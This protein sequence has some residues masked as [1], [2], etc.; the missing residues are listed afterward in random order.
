MKRVSSPMRAASTSSSV[1]RCARMRSRTSSRSM[2]AHSARRRRRLGRRP[3]T[4]PAGADRKA[5]AASS[6]AAVRADHLLVDRPLRQPHRVRD[7]ARAE[8]PVR[9]DDRLAQAEQDRA[10]D[11]PRGR[12]RRAGRAACRGS[13]G[14]RALDTGPERIASRIAPHERFDG[15]SITFSATL[16]VKPSVTTTSTVA[17]REVE[18]LDVAGEVER[19]LGEPL[20]RR[21]HRRACPCPTPRRPTAA[22][23]AGA[24][25]RTHGLHEAGAHVG[26]LDEVLGARLDAGAGVEQQHRA[27]GHRQQHGQRRPEDARGCA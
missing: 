7:A 22:P 26:E 10:A 12:A 11:A 24:R 13:A 8:A 25:C 19:A 9:D 18:A 3:T 2:V 17:A 4:L 23:R 6:A 14:R 27:A 5:P 21:E 1:A 15:P 16:P 20:V